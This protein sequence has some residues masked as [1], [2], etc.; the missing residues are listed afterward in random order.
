M[1]TTTSKSITFHTKILQTGKNT[2]GIQVPEEI[3][4][5]LASGKQPLVRMTIKNHTYPSSVAVMDGKFMVSLSAE[6]RKAA[7]VKGG[8]EVD[9]TIELDLEPRKVEIPDDLMAALNNAGALAAFQR[10]APSM[11]KEYVRQVME[12]KAQ[13]TR[14]R[15]IRKIVEK[16]T[17]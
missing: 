16:L 15:R 13:E 8:E 12:A 7:D 14:Q 10:S 4:E 17:E 11:R 3:I 9:V 6:N 5:K 2:T 1:E